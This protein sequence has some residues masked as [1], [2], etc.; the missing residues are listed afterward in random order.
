MGIGIPLCST[1]SEFWVQQ[2]RRHEGDPL[3]L[4]SLLVLRESRQKMP[5][6][7]SLWF[8]PSSTRLRLSLGGAVWKTE[9]TKNQRIARNRRGRLENVFGLQLHNFAIYIISFDEKHSKKTP[10]VTTLNFSAG[11]SWHFLTVGD[12]VA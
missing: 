8:S 7:F 1:Y 10:C 5:C 9:I 3:G 11:N 2:Q 6:F 4:Q 12:T